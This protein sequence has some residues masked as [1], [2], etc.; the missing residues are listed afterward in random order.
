MDV[1]IIHRQHSFLERAKEK[2]LLGGWHVQTTDCGLDGL[3][4]ARHHRF[5]LMLTGFDLPV[6]S[7]TELVRSTRLLSVNQ[8]MPVFFIKAGCESEP[9]IELAA[10]MQVNF[11]DE[12]EMDGIGKMAC[13]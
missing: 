13:L 1:L 2:F 11:M 7:G 3:L 6:I 9:Q 10:R 5:D 12:C 8:K 4:T